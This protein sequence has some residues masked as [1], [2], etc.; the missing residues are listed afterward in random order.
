LPLAF[1]SYL[2][3]L[4]DLGRVDIIVITGDVISPQDYDFLFKAGVVG[5]FW[6]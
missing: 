2:I 1:Y 6:K 3:S 4:T 5:V